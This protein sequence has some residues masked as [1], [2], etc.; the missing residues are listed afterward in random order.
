VEKAEM[1]LRQVKKTSVYIIARAG[2]ELNKA[3][4]MLQSAQTALDQATQQ[5]EKTTIRAPF[6]G[7]AIHSETYR[8]GQ[9]RKPRI[10]DKVLQNQPILYLPE[11]SSMVVHAMIR[12]IDLHKVE[13]GQSCEVKADA[14]P[15]TTYHGRVSFIGAMATR[16][17]QQNGSNFFRLTVAIEEDNQRLRPGMTA[18]VNIITSSTK[19][20]LTVPLQA[21]F[22]D[23]NTT[24]C[25][26]L[27]S[28]HFVASPVR[29]G[30]AGESSVTVLDGL[31]DGDVVSLVPIDVHRPLPGT[32][33]R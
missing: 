31:S 1:E 29:L 25:Y 26:R 19:D 17:N 9:R 15:G 24:I 2:A 14:F 20:A 4:T 11:I 23:N 8:A 12:E 28:K 22:R 27:N 33:I 18:R 13:I 6:S 3:K 16:M 10:G 7:I 32:A 30:P 21:V 5:V